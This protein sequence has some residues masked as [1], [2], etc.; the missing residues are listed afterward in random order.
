MQLLHCIKQVESAGGDN[1][2]AD[3]FRAAKEVKR[4]RPDFYEIL[5]SSIV[6]FYDIGTDYYEF[7]KFSRKPVIS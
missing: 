6:E 1:Q 4:L 7:H 5:C 3:G 2:F